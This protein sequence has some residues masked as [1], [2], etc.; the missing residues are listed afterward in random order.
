MTE[1]LVISL[2]GPRFSAFCGRN[3]AT[4][5]DFKQFH[6]VDGAA[7]SHIPNGVVSLESN[8][9]MPA[10]GAALSHRELWRQCLSRGEVLAVFEDDAWLRQD[11][12]PQLDRLLQRAGGW[13]VM[14]FGCNTNTGIELA[15]TPHISLTGRFSVSHPQ[16]EH[17]AEFT[18]MRD[19]VE[20]CR[21]LLAVGICGYAITPR[22]AERLL[23]Y[24][25][26]LDN[27]PLRLTVTGRRVR[28]YGIDCMMADA[29]PKIKAFLCW[30]PLVM[31]PNE[32]R[33]SQIQGNA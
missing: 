30:P 9:S 24:C 4:G 2:N 17:L 10:I 27:R 6:A 8:Y 3:E 15:V 19:A 25:F 16:P 33:S 28:A 20:L 1:C 18:K 14:L 26:P 11:F 22:G 23:Q 13:D 12:E 31:T 5:I 21:V 29:Y 7:L 32:L